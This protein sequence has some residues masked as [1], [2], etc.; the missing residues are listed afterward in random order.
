LGEVVSQN[1]AAVLASLLCVL[2]VPTLMAQ[3]EWDD[4]DRSKKVLSR[5]LAKDY[6]ESCAPNAILFSFGDNDTYP[7]WYA[8]EVEGIRPDIR[9]VNYSLL[10]I[11]WYINEL[12]YK[13]N[14]SDSIDVIWRADQIEAGKRDY[15]VYSPRP[16][17]PEDRYYDLYDVMKNYVGSDDADK[18]DNSRGSE[19]L[20]S[21]PVRKFAVPVD[22]NFVLKN[23]VV[24]A[25]DSIL[26]E[27]RFDVP[28]TSLMKND[29][30]VLNIIAAN[31]WIRP[32]YFTTPDLNLGFD[33]FLRRDGLSHRLVPV[34]NSKVNTDWM[35]SKSLNVFSSGNANVKG[36]YFDEENRRHLNTIRNAYAELAIDLSAKNRKEDA[37]KVLDKVD[38]MMLQENFPYGMASRGNMHNKN[39]L[40]FLEACLMADNKVLA[41]KVA[42]SVK[43]DLQQQVKFCNSLTGDKADQM[44]DEKRM[45]ESY[46]KGLEQIEAMYNP[47][48]QIPGKMMA[49]DSG[50][51]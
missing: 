32:I 49:A 6:L 3:Q 8:Q 28:K 35:L 2:A 17:I 14:Q 21:F 25:D 19:P 44:A 34:A 33:Q 12:R 47:R 26:K 11:D 13:V 42:A 23:K 15:V 39:S 43:K 41:E 48:I 7:L 31:K 24:N 37:R 16:N 36:V 5:D 18:L 27:L 10:G 38:E 4:H 50:K 40:L 20:N 51:K 30:A 1:M 46:L 9:V 22:A 29:L 45:A